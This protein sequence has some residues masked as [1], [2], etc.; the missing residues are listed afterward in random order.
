[1]NHHLHAR[2]LRTVFAATLA[3]ACSPA[4]AQ[5]DVRPSIFT[6]VLYTDNVGFRNG[7]FLFDDDSGQ[8]DDISYAVTPRIAISREGARWNLESTYQVQVRRFVEFDENRENLQNFQLESDYQL[9][10]DR[11]G[12]LVNAGIEQFV[13][14]RQLGIGGTTAN[15]IANLTEFRNAAIEPY[16]TFDIGS[17]TS[18]R[19]SYRRGEN[20]V[21]G[22]GFDSSNEQIR[23]TINTSLAGGRWTLGGT[24]TDS[25]VEF[26]TGRE[27]SLQRIAL[28]GAYRLTPRTQI[29][30][31]VG[32][33]SNDIGSDSVFGDVEGT[34]WMAGVRGKVGAAT[35]YELRAG[36][37]F[38]GNSIF[39]S[40]E[41]TRG[42]LTL[43]FS[44]QEQANTFGGGAISPQAL[45]A[46]TT[47]VR[48]I[49]LPNATQDVFISNLLSF[50]MAYTR[51]RSTLSF[52]IFNDNREFLSGQDAL[53]QDD[54]GGGLQL[55]YSLEL[56]PES[57]LRFS[58][59]Y[60]RFTIRRTQDEPEDIRVELGW[61]RS[62]LERAYMDLRFVHN[63]RQSI[64]STQITGSGNFDENTVELGF[65]YEFW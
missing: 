4:A 55:S 2:A 6:S 31:Q 30:M 13:I 20:E 59:T 52:N 63:Q 60:Q 24:F 45:I 46:L 62:V 11:V 21:E 17:N 28:D 15:R 10:I 47:D 43:S 23:A 25:G 33:D 7:L 16:Y 58:G 37:Q 56:S 48:G 51:P 29:V 5:W 14:D 9:L 64:T 19:L 18:G 41:R 65:G 8:T 34:F 22:Q 49:D 1:M 53:Q 42:R 26:E 35:D 54:R 40:V 39:A 12:F 27:V 3:L 61:R 36:R 38:F 57:R 50:G 44:Y 32:Q